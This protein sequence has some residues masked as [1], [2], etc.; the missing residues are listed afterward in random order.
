MLAQINQSL[1]RLSRAEQRV[2]QLPCPLLPV[3]DRRVQLPQ[4]VGAGQQTAD[5]ARLLQQLAHGL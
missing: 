2:A 4:P 1:P 3:D 5:L